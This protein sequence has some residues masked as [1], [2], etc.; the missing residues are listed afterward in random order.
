M[1]CSVQVL[2]LFFDKTWVHLI[3]TMASDETFHAFYYTT[4]FFSVSQVDII[5]KYVWKFVMTT[6]C[7]KLHFRLDYSCRATI[8]FSRNFI[9]TLFEKFKLNSMCLIFLM[10]CSIKRYL[11]CIVKLCEVILMV[12]YKCNHGCV[13]FAK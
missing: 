4:M 8:I 9:A 6:K 5:G 11:R 7:T 10:N 13:F 12:S 3:T 1:S 2:A